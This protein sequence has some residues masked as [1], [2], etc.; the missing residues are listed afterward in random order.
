M[1][2][3]LLF[4]ILCGN[5]DLDPEAMTLDEEMLDLPPRE[6]ANE[7]WPDITQNPNRDALNLSSP[8]THVENLVH[9]LRTYNDATLQTP[10][11]W[12]MHDTTCTVPMCTEFKCIERPISRTQKI[13]KEIGR[14]KTRLRTMLACQYSF[15][16][17][18]GAPV[19]FFLGTFVFTIVTTLSNLG[20]NDTSLALAFGMWYMIIPH[21][22]IV[23]GLL[24]AGNNPST[25]EGVV[26]HEFGD[27]DRRLPAQKHLGTRIFELAYDSRYRPQWLWFRGRSK[28]HWIERVWK[29]YEFRHPAGER[30]PMVPDEDMVALRRAAALSTKSWGV[31]IGMTLLLMGRLSRSTRLT[32]FNFI[33]EMQGCPS[34]SPFLQLSTPRRSES[35]VGH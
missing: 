4:V 15:G 26:A 17:T 14:A 22:S 18:V 24:L 8:W 2:A 34:Y 30:G 5:L 1:K 10:R 11:Q 6:V 23:S 7:K 9:E 28:R 25:L 21:I 31:I 35:A 27:T 29:T 12:P 19:V 20:D 32:R 3:R 13:Q 33:D 16:A